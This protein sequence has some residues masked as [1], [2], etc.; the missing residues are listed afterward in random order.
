MTVVASAATRARYW[1]ALSPAMSRSGGRKVLSVMG[2]ATLPARTEGED[3]IERDTVVHD[4]HRDA[5]LQPHSR[6]RSLTALSIARGYSPASRS[7]G[8]LARS[9]RRRRASSCATDRMEHHHAILG[10]NFGAF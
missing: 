10:E 5:F 2:L 1:L 8:R 9:S 7:G 3:L 4:S 6:N